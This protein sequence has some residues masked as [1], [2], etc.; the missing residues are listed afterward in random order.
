MFKNSYAGIRKEFKKG[1]ILTDSALES[2]AD[3][4]SNSSFS[5][6]SSDETVCSTSRRASGDTSN[7]SSS[8]QKNS[9]G[10]I[11]I[12][13]VP[14]IDEISS[15][16]LLQWFEKIQQTMFATQ[17]EN[18]ADCTVKVIPDTL[19]VLKKPTTSSEMKASIIRK[20][21]DYFEEKLTEAGN[22]RA[23]TMIKKIEPEKDKFDLERFEQLLN[24]IVKDHRVAPPL[25]SDT[26]EDFRRYSI[27]CGGRG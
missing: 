4:E 24:R 13:L 25:P 9:I 8:P 1:L 23:L 2:D 6:D 26:E 15:D 18:Y 11:P 27:R 12:R 22:K 5:S 21:R 17:P 19:A 16:R 14:L 10:Y 7:L 20:W 3:A